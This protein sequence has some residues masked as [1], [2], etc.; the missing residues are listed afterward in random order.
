VYEGTLADTGRYSFSTHNGDITMTV[1]ETANATFNVRTYNGEF[2]TALTL[3]GPARSEL[4]RGKR[5]A[6]TLGNG[7]AEVEMESFGGAIRL[8]RA[9]AARGRGDK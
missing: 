9:G 2:G 1:P 4:R 7:N 8:R 6:Y 5:A 3:K